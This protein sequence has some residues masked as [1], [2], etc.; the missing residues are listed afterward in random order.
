MGLLYLSLLVYGA[1]IILIRD[2][3]YLDLEESTIFLLW[4][5]GALVLSSLHKDVI[6]F[7]V[8]HVAAAIFL[9]SS[10]GNPVFFELI[11]L[12]V[13]FFA[14]NWFF[15]YKKIVTVF[16]LLFLVLSVFYIFDFFRIDTFWLM[17]CYLMLGLLMVHVHHGLN[18]SVFRSVGLGVVGVAG[19]VMTFSDLWEGVININ[20]T[21]LSVPFAIGLTGYMFMLI[22]K[23]Q[24]FP[25]IVIGAL[26]LRYYF[27]TLYG[28]MPRALFFVIGGLMI[29]GIG[30][31][32]ERYRKEEQA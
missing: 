9:M 20:G 10:L 29:L 19:V 31:F 22:S 21:W 32:I 24:V 18:R 14:G 4:T 7:L 17:L 27:D 28:F 25:L 5:A 16:S 3:F 13:L 15:G 30:M 23:K 11:A 8:A 6:L 26:I 2:M 1:G 12:I